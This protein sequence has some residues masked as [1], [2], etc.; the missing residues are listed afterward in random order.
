MTIGQDGGTIST[1]VTD[2]DGNPVAD[3]L[4]LAMPAGTSSEGVLASRITTGQTDQ[5][6]QYQSG[7]LA[8]GTYY[9]VATDDPYDMTPECISKLWQSHIKYEKVDLA[10]SGAAQLNLHLTSI[11]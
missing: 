1:H 2:K 4:I 3:A 6:G 9:V 7:T 8:P 11:R 5:L 10:P